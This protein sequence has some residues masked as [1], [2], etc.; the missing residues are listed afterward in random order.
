MYFG[1]AVET[2]KPFQSSVALQVLNA[3]FHALLPQH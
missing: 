3:I 2:A 1:K